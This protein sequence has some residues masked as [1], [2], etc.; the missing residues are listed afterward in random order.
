[1]KH[2]FFKGGDHARAP[3]EC[4][5]HPR[6]RRALGGPRRGLLQGLAPAKRV[7]SPRGT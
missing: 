6:L 2:V 7:L 3:G 5:E 1:M 4:A